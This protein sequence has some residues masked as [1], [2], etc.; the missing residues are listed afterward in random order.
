MYRAEYTSIG[1]LSTTRA[2]STGK[3][4][5]HKR[6]R[7]TKAIVTI[8]DSALYID[9]IAPNTVYQRETTSVLMELLCGNT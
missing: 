4:F 1:K 3:K 6:S 5:N 9:L 8:V 2:A 7:T